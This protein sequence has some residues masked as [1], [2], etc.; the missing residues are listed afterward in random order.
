MCADT[1][2]WCAANADCPGDA[3]YDVC[4]GASSR[5][6]TSKRALRRAIA[7]HAN[8]V[9]FG[10]MSTYQGKGV[11]SSNVGSE[12]FPYVKLQSCSGLSTVT[13]TKL[14]ARGELEAA[15]CFTMTN[16][17]S[18]SC[19][20]DY[21]GNGAVNNGNATLNQVTYSLVGTSDSRWDIPRGD[22]SG[23]SVRLDTS[24]SSCATS[25]ILPACTF[26]GQGTGLY[27]GSYYTFTYKQGTPVANGG[28]DG[29]GSRAHPVYFTTYRG[30]YYSDGANCYSAVDTD[31][32]DIVNDGIYGRPAYT[33]H[34]Y[35]YANEVPVP[36]GGSTNP[37]TCDATTGATWNQNVV[38][39]LADAAFGGQSITTAQRTLM[40]V[41]RLEKASYGG[42]DATGSL[43]PLGCALKNDAVPDRYHSAADYMSAVQTTDTA[44]NGGNPPCWSNN[45]VLVVD[46][47]SNGAGDYGG[48]VDCASTA[49]A[50]NA[51]TNPTLAGCNCTA[52]VKA[53]NLAHAALPVQTH[54]VVN[55]PSTWSARFPYAYGFLWNLALAGS[56]NFDGTPSFGTSEDEVYRAISAKIAAAAYRLTFTTTSAVAG[57][58]TQNPDSSVV[59]ES[60]FLYDTSVSYPSWKG[61]V[62]AFDTT[63]SVDLKWDAVTVAATGHPTDWTHRRIFFSSKNGTVVQVQIGSNGSITNASALYSE[64]L[65]ASS[66]EAEKIMQWLLGKPELGN[67]APLMGSIT[68]STPIVVGQAAA[69][70]LNGASNYSKA[71]WKRPQLVYVG[72]D[73]GM[74]HAFFAQAGNTTL[75]G[76]SYSGGEEAFAFIPSDMLQVIAKQY[77]QGRQKLSVDRSDH[78]FGLA[79]SPKVKDMC[80]GSACDQSTGS[81]WHTILVMPEGPGGNKPFA[82]DITNVINETTGLH[83]SNMTL[84]WSTA[85]SS[86]DIRWD[87]G[88]GEGRSLPGFYFAGYSGSRADNRVI[89]AS[90]YPT[91]T[92][93]GYSKQGLVVLNADA[94][95]GTVKQTTDVSSLGAA[96]CTQKR[97]VMSDVSVARDYTSL[98][99]SQSLLAAYVADTWGNTFEYVPAATDSTK[100]LTKL[101]SLGCGQPL[102]FAPA[103]VQ[104]DRAPKADAS[105]KHYI[106]LVQVTNSNE[107]PDTE[108]V[109]ATYP[110]SQMVVTKLDGNVSPPVIV[111]AYNSL[112]PSGQIILS[113]DTHATAANRI[114]IQTETENTP[115]DFTDGL[116]KA[117]QTCAEANGEPLPSTARPVGTPTAVLRADGLGFQVI[118]GW[119]DPT[120]RSNNC[121]SG[122]TFYYG[123]SYV[124]VHE[125]GADGTWYQL[126]GVAIDNAVLTGTS[127]I[128]TG[129][130]VDGINAASTPQAINIDETFSSVQQSSNS[131]GAERYSR[132][133]WSERL[134]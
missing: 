122:H 9:N 112:E 28:I 109:T 51:A 47:L 69:N 46:G 3:T 78:V 20:V 58:S 118:T 24:W 42:V 93:S 44:N 123:K 76:A 67:P 34:P 61:T 131:K 82:L 41:A 16:G 33:G 2:I 86:A 55:A 121:S 104:L 116:K 50:Y 117:S 57:A 89:F 132:T 17:P 7:D 72:G 53:Y 30:K 35:D 97:T 115:N 126:A 77:A 43:A 107:D 99:T 64:G 92:G 90:G 39:F 45:I 54:V 120:V 22:G 73:D 87:Q 63:S 129:L 101:Y 21:G 71:T 113:L 125:F 127:F 106:Y 31:R 62:R 94:S 27:E 79:G 88:L 19:V 81:D 38:P 40:T 11:G 96:T 13:E 134:D 10:F 85:L 103:L 119:Y 128:G 84:L 15:G 75:N 37:N 100:I 65:G 70:G 66:I 18:T 52:I 56:P 111:T 4:V 105:A 102:Y 25:P 32:S 6:M 80:I 1:G 133:S 83:P 74:L 5:M 59:T 26:V 130:F 110:P 8:K 60:N 98:S 14:L 124:T 91:E 68:A 48:S 29:E 108:A 49:C 23:K 114:C 36:W 12:I 95:N